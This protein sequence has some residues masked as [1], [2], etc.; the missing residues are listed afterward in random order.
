MRG[1]LSERVKGVDDV[2]ISMF[3]EDKLVIGPK[4]PAPIGA[5]I[6][7]KPEVSVVLSWTHMDFDRVLSIALAGQLKFAYLCF[8]K[9]QYGKSLV[10]S[11]SFSNELE[12]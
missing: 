2:V 10:V 12:E 8:T 7:L 11:A 4:G 5:I 6:G 1:K 9:P 3:P